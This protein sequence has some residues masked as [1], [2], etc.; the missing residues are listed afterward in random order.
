MPDTIHRPD[1][2]YT[3]DRPAVRS[4]DGSYALTQLLE[5]EVL[6]SPGVIY[7]RIKWRSKVRKRS[8]GRYVAIERTWLRKAPLRTRLF[9]RRD[10]LPREFLPIRPIWGLARRKKTPQPEG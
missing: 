3:R 6:V 7:R 1:G 8:I 10:G 4:D 5:D 2:E 9:L